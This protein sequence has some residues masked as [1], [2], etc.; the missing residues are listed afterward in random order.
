MIKVYKC[1]K[2]CTVSDREVKCE[3]CG[4]KTKFLCD[5]SSI[6]EREILVENLQRA[7]FKKVIKKK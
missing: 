4:K 7:K 3:K 6:E 5:V 1:D 2:L